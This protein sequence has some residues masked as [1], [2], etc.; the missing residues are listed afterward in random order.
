MDTF[1]PNPFVGYWKGELGLFGQSTP[2]SVRFTSDP[3]QTENVRGTIDI[4][5][6]EGLPLSEI[7]TNNNHLHFEL[8]VTSSMG[9]AV[10]D[11]HL[12]ESTATIQKVVGKFQQAGVTC[13]HLKWIL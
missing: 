13:M 11:G 12:V 2:F 8:E 4:Q 5:G 6:A 1:T 7:R 9:T 3:L 10:F